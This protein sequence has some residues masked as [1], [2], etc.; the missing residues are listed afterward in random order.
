MPSLGS[1][2]ALACGPRIPSGRLYESYPETGLWEVQQNRPSPTGKLHCRTN[3]CASCVQKSLA[4]RATGI[5]SSAYCRSAVGQ[6][7]EMGSHMPTYPGLI[8][9]LIIP[10]DQPR[11]KPLQIT[12]LSLDFRLQRVSAAVEILPRPHGLA[13]RLRSV[14]W[15]QIFDCGSQFERGELRSAWQRHRHVHMV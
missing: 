1:L 2:N 9:K 12:G 14:H 4:R 3:Q 6:T 8:Q 7:S 13:A 15:N 5:D 10:T 11:S